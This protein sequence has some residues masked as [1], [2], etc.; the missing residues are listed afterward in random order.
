MSR[1]EYNPFAY[2]IHEDPYPTYSR[3]REEAPV[4]YHAE[5]DFYALSR[6]ADVLAALKD[7]ERFTNTH[8]VSVERSA[9]HP[10]A[11]LAM[12]FLGMDP[13]RHTQMRALVSRGF[14]PRRV[15]A[16]EP[17][18]RE[19]AVD[20]LERM[21]A[22]GRS[23]FIAD[24]AGVL[25]MDVISELLGV[26]SPDRAELRRHAELLVHREEGVFDVPRAA[27]GAFGKIWSYFAERIEE[28][29]RS[30][31][32][33]LISALLAAEIDGQRLSQI[34]IQSF[35]NLMIVA[36][37]ETTTK[38]LA[39]A[40]YWLWRNPDQRKALRDDPARIPGWVE[41]T[42]RFDSSTQAIGRVTMRPLQLHGVEIPAGKRVLV[43]IGS[44]NR[45]ER[46]FPRP[47]A[48]DLDRD[49]SSML[50]FGHGAHF[51]LGAALA[52]LEART[53]LEEFW[54]RFPGFEVEAAGCERIHS[55]SVRG[56][57]ALPIELRGD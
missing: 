3:L 57:A 30:P 8:G 7:T 4:Y 23:E 41:E 50:S 36:G 40:L 54:K 21:R 9:S 15:A 48:Y 37:N 29:R 56:F 16:L 28:R 17:R 11:H 13:P 6:H 20:A 19:M 24:L 52:R 45:D 1:L 22:R 5:L 46:A 43:L 27:A 38:L 26:P 34:D 32:E 44:G 2:E 35:C 49:T 55:V 53:V 10:A 12:S 47:D 14:T 25:P 33:D 18:I 42:L 31:K 51:C 39:N